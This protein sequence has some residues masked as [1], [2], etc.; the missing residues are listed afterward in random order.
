M[1]RACA[2]PENSQTDSMVRVSFDGAVS[3][4]VL[5]GETY[6]SDE[7]CLDIKE[8]DYLVF[9]WTVKGTRMAYTPNK[10]IPAFIRDENGNYIESAEFQQPQLIGCDAD[11]EK[12]IA[13]LGDSITIGLG[14]SKDEYNLA[15]MSLASIGGG[16]HIRLS[17]GVLISY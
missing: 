4:R 1:G 12:N 3:K 10:I 2:N 7:A 16:G 9:E 8:G 13:F 6:W 11:F 14:T 17:V 5:S 15:L